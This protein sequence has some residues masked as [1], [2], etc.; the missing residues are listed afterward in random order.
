MPVGSHT[1]MHITE[2]GLTRWLA[3]KFNTFLHTFM[4]RNK[5][6]LG[7]IYLR[8]QTVQEIK[9]C[10]PLYIWS[11][12][13]NYARATGKKLYMELKPTTLTTVW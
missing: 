9:Y 8:P 10:N 12:E 3:H 5:D 13:S 4:F 1:K 7:S 6:R 2:H 11:V